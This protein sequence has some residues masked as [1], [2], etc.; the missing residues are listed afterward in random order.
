MQGG[1]EVD[2]A[3]KIKTQKML[4]RHILDMAHWQSDFAL[5]ALSGDAEYMEPP[6]LSYVEVGLPVETCGTL[7]L[8]HKSLEAAIEEAAGK[9]RPLPVDDYKNISKIVAS[10]LEMLA[11]AIDMDENM[12]LVDRALKVVTEDKMIGQLKREMSRLER[13][14]TVF[15]LANLAIDQPEY[16]NDILVQERL[17]EKVLD[18][19][20]NFDDAFNLGE[21]ETVLCLKDIDILDASSVL[22]RLCKEIAETDFEGRKITLSCGVTEPVEGDKVQSLLRGIRGVRDDAQRAGG[23]AVY[24]HEEKS[25]LA[26]LAEGGENA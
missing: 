13:N 25:A 8:K 10:Y 17:N 23:N 18:I 14:N 2:I 7:K 19:L 11:D 20:R 26:R 1:N 16:K 3:D 24:E 6:K 22:E 12:G 15:C 5:F 9:G 21:T 4:L